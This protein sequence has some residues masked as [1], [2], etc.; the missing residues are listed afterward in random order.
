MHISLS[1][2]SIFSSPFATLHICLWRGKKGL[3][4]NNQ[5]QFLLPSHS[6][7]KPKNKIKIPQNS[8]SFNANFKLFSIAL[9]CLI[10][11]LIKVFS[12]LELSLILN[13]NFLRLNDTT[14][15]NKNFGYTYPSVLIFLMVVAGQSS[16]Y[17][18]RNSLFDPRGTYLPSFKWY[19]E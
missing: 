3:P 2:S 15:I 8:W 19:V 18:R 5:L 14:K 13:Q 16:F 1:Q 11:Y 10:Y 4:I 6:F 9:N 12:R 7:V 17:R